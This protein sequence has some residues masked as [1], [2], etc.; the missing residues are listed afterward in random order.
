MRRALKVRTIMNLLGPCLNP[1]RPP[2]QLLG[3]AEP[4]LMRPIAETLL[5]LGVE[6]G[7]VVHGNGLDEIAPHSET[8]VIRIADGALEELVLTPEEAG[9]DRRPLDQISGG[10][11][12]EN[13]KRLADLLQGRGTDADAQVVA[14]NTGALLW[15]AGV[16]ESF[17][18]G[19]QRALDAMDRGQAGETLDAFV[20]ASN[21]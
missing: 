15:T 21:G 2:V 10:C 20:E 4:K 6:R 1:A 18:D 11:P 17:R 7:L 16:A 9:F 5:A 3:V 19:A 13:A 8:Q 14:L 12:E